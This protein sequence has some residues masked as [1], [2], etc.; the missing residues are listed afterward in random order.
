[1]TDV[2]DWLRQLDAAT[3]RLL[4]TTQRLTDDDI[5]RPSLLPGWTAG[6]VVT[7]LARN[8]D[9]LV[10]LATSARTGE[11]RPQYV[12]QEE[13]DADIE[14]GAGRPAAEQH[15]DL[16]AAAE[17]LREAL[18]AVPDDRW[19]VVVE[20]RTGVRR[21]AGT[22]PS[23]RL[24]EVEVHHADLGLDYGFG[25]IPETLRLRLLADA[26]GGWPEADGVVLYAED[27]DR[28]FPQRTGVPASEG[29]AAVTPKL[30]VRG[31]SGDLLGWATGRTSGERLS[32]DGP[33]PAVPNWR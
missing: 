5:A 16:A 3:E 8:A 2:A 21:P 32:C 10:N 30:T 24:T 7:H 4:A 26:A 14:A 18:D 22:I 20:W 11:S 19:Q 17:R 13:R 6:H 23:A 29:A 31:T 28:T 1:M 27:A 33:L 25:D 12:S 15:A 9:S